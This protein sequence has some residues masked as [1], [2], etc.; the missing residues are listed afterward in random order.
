M[1]LEN[2]VANLEQQKGCDED[3]M[4]KGCL[5]FHEHAMIIDG[6]EYNI[7]EDVPQELRMKY[8]NELPA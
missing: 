2:R 3:R 6:I 1:S 4:L 7:I 5:Y 8:A